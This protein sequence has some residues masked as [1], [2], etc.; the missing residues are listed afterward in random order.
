MLFV[1]IYFWRTLLSNGYH[2]HEQT[3]KFR[4]L[5]YKRVQELKSH[6]RHHF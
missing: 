2:F 4:I 3:I 1:S 5:L 6:P